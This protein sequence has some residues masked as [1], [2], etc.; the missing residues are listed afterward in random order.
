MDFEIVDQYDRDSIVE[1]DCKIFVDNYSKVQ[2]AVSL[3]HIYCYKEIAEKYEYALIFE[4]D[5]VFNEMFSK[6]LHTYIEELPED[7]DMLFIGDGCNL[8]IDKS[9]FL[10]NV[11]VYKTIYSRCTDSYIISK[12][13]AKTILNYINSIQYKIDEPIDTWLNRVIKDNNLIV[14]WAEPTIVSQGSQKGV[15]KSCIR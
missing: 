9:L 5:A 14:Y 1:D 12:K 15:F 13:C 8:H 4:D 2:I 7:Y 6:N 10:P 11:N 3:S